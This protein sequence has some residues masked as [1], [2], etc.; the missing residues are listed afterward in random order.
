MIE[1]WGLA[2]AYEGRTVLALEHLALA[3]GCRLALV[4]PNGSGKSTLL[5]ILAFLEVPAAGTLHLGGREVGTGP[6]RRAA[7]RRVTLVEQRPYLFRR[8]VLE[9]VAYPLR[10]RG[11]PAAAARRRAHEALDRL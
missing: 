8:T 9:N 7:R 10:L 2:H 1:A 5:R 4:G 3:P 11:V 6:D